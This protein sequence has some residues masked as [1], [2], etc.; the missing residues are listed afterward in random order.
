M[1]IKKLTLLRPRWFEGTD[2]SDLI[3]AAAWQM[4]HDFD[5]QSYWHTYILYSHK[6]IPYY[7]VICIYFKLLIIKLQ[8]YCGRRNFIQKWVLFT[9]VKICLTLSME[10]AKTFDTDIHIDVYF[11]DRCWQL[12][13]FDL[14]FGNNILLLKHVFVCKN[15]NI[16]RIL[17]LG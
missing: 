17:L 8:M 14:L 9:S 15:Y 2:K 11:F 13:I 12:L 7:G 4:F 16:S 1:R 6:I 10:R 3:L 5:G